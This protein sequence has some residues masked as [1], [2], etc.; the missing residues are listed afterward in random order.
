MV[1]ALLAGGFLGP[2]LLPWIPGRAFAFKGIV[3]GV[4]VSIGLLG[5]N[6]FRPGSAAVLPEAGNPGWLLGLS[7]AAVLT[8]LSSYLT[9]NFTGCSTYTSPTG[10]ARE[11][12][13]ALP[14][15]LAAGV[16]GLLGVMV[17]RLLQTFLG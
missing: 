11:M 15:Q 14:V 7:G 8:A 12:R 13:W 5:I 1:A 4:A 17:A 6:G 10:V 9:M 2:V 3:V 16:V